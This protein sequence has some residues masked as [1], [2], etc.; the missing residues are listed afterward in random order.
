MPVQIVLPTPAAHIGPGYTIHLI[1][2][3]IG[4]IQTGSEFVL[5]ISEDPEFRTNVIQ[6]FIPT[7]TTVVVPTV[8]NR[9]QT[10]LQ[11]DGSVVQANSTVHVQAQLRDPNSITIDSGA[12]T[13]L[14][15]PLTML[16]Q[17]VNQASSTIQGGFTQT[18]RITM[19]GIGEAVQ[20]ALAVQ[21][22]AG[23]LID[24]GRQIFRFPFELLARGAGGSLVGRGTLNPPR[25]PTG[26][27]FAYGMLLNATIVPP[28]FSVRD[29]F[30]QTYPERIGQLVTLHQS[31]HIAQNMTTD[32]FVL[33]VSTRA[34]RWSDDQ[35][36]LI[37]YDITP[38]CTVDY[39]WLTGQ[40]P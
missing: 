29:G 19:E 35:P 8:G 7:G 22:A 1:S 25:L 17:Q 23:Q 15:D 39:F 38:G 3:F 28:G 12:I 36:V 30:I 6:Q 32:V 4:P 9:A 33:D 20:T 31:Q 40:S 16:W 21:S 5:S 14:Y 2:D 10:A 27:T 37:G 18:D 34:W 11:A 13:T 26:Q 24:I